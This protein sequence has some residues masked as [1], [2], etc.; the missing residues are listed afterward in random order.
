MFNFNSQVNENWKLLNDLHYLVQEY[1]E[2]GA[3]I[4]CCWDWLEIT[5]LEHDLAASTET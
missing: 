3:P 4:P 5:F 2:T 1:E